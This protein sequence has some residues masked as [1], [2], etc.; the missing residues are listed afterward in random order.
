MKFSVL[1]HACLYIEH[2]GVRLITDPWLF[3]S[4]YW[5]SWWNY[6]EPDLEVIANL[7][8]THVYLTHLH[9]DHYHGPSLR[10]FYKDD[11]VILLPKCPTQ[12]MLKDILSDFRFS[13]VQE[14]AHGK[15]Y[16]LSDTFEIA[17]Y[18]FNPAFI[19]SSLVVV[20]DGVKLLNANDS[21]VFGFSLAQ[22]IK[23]Y[24]SFDFVFRS[25]SSASPIPYCIDGVDPSLSSRAPSDYSR[26]FVAF[27][28][29]CKAKYAIPFASSH[30]Y[31]REDSMQYNAFYNNPVNILTAHRQC[32]THSQCV[33]MPATS[34]WSTEDGF[35]LADHNYEHIDLHVN[36]MR[37]RHHQA[38]ESIEVKQRVQL[39]DR[40]AFIAYFQGFT[41]ALPFFLRKM[42]IGFFLGNSMDHDVMGVLA[43]V[44]TRRPSKVQVFDDISFSNQLVVDYSVDFLIR[45]YPAIVNDCTRKHMFN[46]FTPS[47]LLRIYEGTSRG[48]CSRFL[49]LLDLYENDGLPLTQNLQWRQLSIWISRWREAFDVLIYVYLIK[50][51]RLPIY[52]LWANV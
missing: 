14:L 36:E 35:Q 44:D 18:Q 33:L 16:K 1:G 47:K 8:P 24:K 4:C 17:S 45:T 23:R 38:L 34:S 26:E 6:P 5:R 7:H 40:K 2:E 15:K 42:R 3:G 25:H 9:W 27:A 41:S 52:R 20:A 50:V 39:L 29:A 13:R 19:D 28:E 12:R 46:T 49:T 30:V 32:K 21:K 11:P 37:A 31:L 22:I 48:S 10:K 43:I 51:R